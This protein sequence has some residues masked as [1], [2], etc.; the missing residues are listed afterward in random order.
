MTPAHAEPRGTGARTSEEIAALKLREEAAATEFRTL[1]LERSIRRLKEASVIDFNWV[2]PWQQALE[3]YQTDPS[4]FPLGSNSSRQHGVY[5]PFFRTEQELGI[6][7]DISRIVAR[8]NNHAEG[9]VE[10]LTSFVV[11]TGHKFKVTPRDP[12]DKQA[13]RDLTEF[14]DYWA[15]VNEWDDRQQEAFSGSREDGNYLWRMFADDGVMKLRDVW[16]EQM[17]Q[18]P[19]ATFEEYGFGVRSKPGDAETVEEYYFRDIDDPTGDGE[20]VK[21]CDVV[22]FKAN[23]RRKIKCGLPDFCFNAK[24]VLDSAARLTRNM[25]EGSAIREAITLIRQHASASEEEVQQFSTANADFQEKRPPSFDKQQ[26]VRQYE[27]GTELDI[28]DGMEFAGVPANPGTPAHASVVAILLRSA[29][30]KWNA[31]EWLVSGDASNMGA[32]TSSLVAESP[33]VRRI[34]R[35]QLYYKTR[36]IRVVRRA[37]E[38]AESHGVLMRDTL[39]RC[40]LELVPPAPQVRDG[41]QAAQR[42][43][44]EIPLGLDSR[45]RY[46]SEQERDFDQIDTEN[47]Q[48]QDEHGSIGNPLPMPGDPEPGPGAGARTSTFEQLVDGLARLDET[49]RRLVESTPSPAPGR[50]LLENFTGT[51]TDSAGRKRHYVDGK[52]VAAP[53]GG[54]PTAPK[55]APTVDDTLSELAGKLPDA[56]ADPSRWAKVKAA[57]AKVHDVAWGKAF[58]LADKINTLAPEILDVAQ[59]YEKITYHKSNYVSDHLGVG[60]NTAAVIASHVLARV[61]VWAKQRRRGESL[62]EGEMESAASVLAEL[63]TAIGEPLGFGPVDAGNLESFLGGRQESELLEAFTGTITD[64]MGR[65]RKYVDGKPVA[66]GEGGADDLP[67]TDSHPVDSIVNATDRKGM[68]S[69]IHDYVRGE[70]KAAIAAGTQKAEDVAASLW[71]EH[72]EEFAKHGLSQRDVTAA[73]KR[74]KS[75]TAKAYR[76]AV[77]DKV[78]DERNELVRDVLEKRANKS[79]AIETLRDKVLPGFKDVHDDAIDNIDITADDVRD[80]LADR[81]FPAAATK[82][83]DGLTDDTAPAELYR[84]LESAG[85][86]IDPPHEGESQDSFFSR[87]DE[88]VLE[89]QQQAAETII[90]AWFRSMSK[91][92]R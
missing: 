4:W 87:A 29:A 22:H 18:P 92:G 55:D 80:V 86:K 68:A 85:L 67:A 5:F 31:P 8:T 52:P 26:F 64:S 89:A 25:G 2:G 91:P 28:P 90:E 53:Q 73:A 81:G 58:D 24:D 79:E 61:I 76:V 34:T 21:A 3:K 59:D 9:M 45:Q 60:A 65:E 35:A 41:L 39:K 20:R 49:V 7:R 48:Y 40:I 16:P 36:F 47:Q 46:C 57:V 88:A 23:S 42:A 44:I 19:D 43:A 27:P 13:A 33:F 63:M 77:P 83:M 78:R 50:L 37:V 1:R 51:I 62:M 38:I 56:A 75:A 70:E 32:Y 71:A 66:K 10:G 74:M 6:L 11:G 84:Q 12:A 14:L 30:T 15:A 17:T 69:A 82:V 54:N 72:G